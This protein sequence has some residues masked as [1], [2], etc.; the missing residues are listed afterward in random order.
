MDVSRS[1]R[2]QYQDPADQS[3]P[4][5]SYVTVRRMGCV[6]NECSTLGVLCTRRS[7]HSRCNNAPWCVSCRSSRCGGSDRKNSGAIQDEGDMER[8]GIPGRS[9]PHA[10]HSASNALSF[11][12]SDSRNDC[13]SSVR[14]WSHCRSS[15]CDESC[16]KNFPKRKLPPARLHFPTLPWLAWATQPLQ[17]L[18]P[19]NMGLERPSQCR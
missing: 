16:R 9:H 12:T 8:V 7:A 11:H 4:S 14:V 5:R 3:C 13:G 18:A 10:N 6:N 1:S 19:P 15:R 17:S 2:P